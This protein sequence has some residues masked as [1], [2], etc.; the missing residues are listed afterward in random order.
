MDTVLSTPQG[1]VIVRPGVEADAVSYRELRLEALH[2]HPEVYSS[3][4]EKALSQPMSYWQERLR[5]GGTGDVAQ[6]YFARHEEELVGMCGIFRV[7]AP[8]TRHSATIVS[9]YVRPVWRGLDIA[10]GLIAVCLDWARSH[11]I[12]IVKLAVITT[13]APA[14]RVYER[15][16][17][18]PYGSEPQAI[19]YNGIYYDELLMAR[20]VVQ[21]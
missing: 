17:F 4:Y 21:V 12:R 10:D 3:D 5:N 18:Q 13:N 19:Y 11:D 8:R 1:P 16:G 9:L 2:N 6:M 15:C 14:I 20:P 7:D